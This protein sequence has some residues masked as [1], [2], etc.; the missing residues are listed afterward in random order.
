MKPKILLI[1]TGGTIGMMSDPNTGELQNLDFTYIHNQIPELNRL[2]V[3]LTTISIQHPMDSSHMRP[4]VW[5]E[6]A[7]IIESNATKYDGFVLLHG[8]DT[9]AYTAS[10]LSFLIQGFKKPI[11]LTGSQLPIGVL[12]SDGKENL[13]TAIEEGYSALHEVAVFFQSKLF[14]GNR[15]SKVSSHQFDAFDSPN[16]PLLGSAGVTIALDSARLLSPELLEPQFYKQ[17]DPR[18]GLLKLYP[19]INLKGY[20]SMFK[21]EN[22]RAVVL[23][24]FGSG[25]TPNDSSFGE[26]LHAYVENGGVLVNTS[27]CTSGGVQ[28]GKYASGHLLKALG[29]WDGKDLTTEAAIT[30]LMWLFGNYP[31]VKE[32]DFTNVVGG[33]SL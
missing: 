23:E 4:S 2:D 8:T 5:L 11:V 33:E 30:K 3:V 7:S 14:R 22:Y 27:Q 18:V 26:V 13:L 17:L 9:M 16:Y 21:P 6:I 25:N 31:T 20:S 15:T 12:R 19:G 28:P 1:Y 24:A 32:S 29:A 10:A